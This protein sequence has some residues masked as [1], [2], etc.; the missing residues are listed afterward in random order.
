MERLTKV[1]QKELKTTLTE[2]RETRDVADVI[3]AH[4]ARLDSIWGT[5]K[6][7]RVRTKTDA[8]K[9]YSEE[10]VLAY[11]EHKFFAPE[12]QNWSLVNGRLIGFKK[13]FWAPGMKR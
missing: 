11:V 12:N 3:A 13:T 7:T 6:K 10:D 1:Q 8:A 4:N 2:I 9:I 5:S